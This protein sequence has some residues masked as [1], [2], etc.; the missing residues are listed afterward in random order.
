MGPESA[1]LKAIGTCKAKW[2]GCTPYCMNDWFLVVWLNCPLRAR[3][4]GS[5][6]NYDYEY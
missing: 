6:I 1:R 2:M 3:P 5:K 4:F